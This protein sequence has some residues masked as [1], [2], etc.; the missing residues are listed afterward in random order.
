MH[1]REI[2]TIKQAYA[3][4][5]WRAPKNRLAFSARF[6]AGKY[7]ENNGVFSQIGRIEVTHFHLIEITCWARKMPKWIYG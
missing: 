6:K 2:F 1:A 7:G 5:N 4:S 3:I